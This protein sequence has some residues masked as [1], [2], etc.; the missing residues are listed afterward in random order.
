MVNVA[1]LAY[2]VKWENDNFS[3]LNFSLVLVIGLLIFANFNNFFINSPN[4]QKKFLMDQDIL[5]VMIPSLQKVIP[6][7]QTQVS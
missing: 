4:K 3:L 1:A 6:N 2:F 5:C 7:I